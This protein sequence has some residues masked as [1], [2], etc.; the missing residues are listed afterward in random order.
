MLFKK[1]KLNKTLHI[2]FFSAIIGFISAIIIHYFTFAA[3]NTFELTEIIYDYIRSHVIYLLILIPSIAVLTFL[4][5]IIAKHFPASRGGGVP[6]TEGVIRGRLKYNWLAAIFGMTTGTLLSIL[7]GLPLG[8]EGPS[9]FIGGALGFGFSNIFKLSSHDKRILATSGACTGLAVAFNTPLAGIIFSVEEAHRKF[10]PSILLPSMVAVIVGI[11]TKKM[12]F[13]DKIYLDAYAL[14]DVTPN[15]THI[16]GAL[17]VGLACGLLGCFFNSVRNKKVAALDRIPSLWKILI[18]AYVAMIFC[19]VLPYTMGVGKKLFI[20]IAVISVGIIALTLLSK[21]LMIV[22]ASRC[23]ASGGIF[24]PM[25]SLGAMTGAL[26][27]QL[28]TVM[29]FQNSIMLLTLMGACSFFTAAVRAPFTAVVMSFEITGFSLDGIFPMIIAVMAGY[30]MAELLKTKPLYENILEHLIQESN[31][32]EELTQIESN[33]TVSKPS[34]ANKHCLRDLILPNN[35]YATKL[36][37]DDRLIKPDGDTELLA[38]DVVSIVH[39]Q[40][41][42]DIEQLQ[43]IF[44]FKTQNVKSKRLMKKDL[45]NNETIQGQPQS[46]NTS[47]V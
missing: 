1:I 22:L 13:G 2:V 4:S 26:I 36:H 15:L 35:S 31:K 30:F 19:L 39:E 9:I 45:N 47:T 17:V 40:T 8:S 3:E 32:P 44:E 29:G 11:S 23:G 28:L 18:A 21:F 25:M 27:S 34:Y 42:E 24:I 46:K 6:Y 37:R 7:M 12:I 38:G 10:S 5:S 43:K 33:F 14:I 16:I 20:D 41:K